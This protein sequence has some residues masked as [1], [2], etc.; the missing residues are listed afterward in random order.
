MADEP[1]LRPELFTAQG[2]ASVP[3]HPALLGGRC[4]SCGYTY[5]PMQLYGC[6]TCGSQDL[7]Q[8]PLSGRGR[9]VAFARVHMHVSPDRQAPFT[10]GSV[11]TD[12]G[13]VVRA[14]IDPASEDALR[15]GALM[16]ALLVAETRD[17]RG[18]DD[19]RFGL[20]SETEA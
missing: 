17:G 19:L 9:L 14:L 3:D 11:V 15:P 18:T 7:V 2:T 13:A 6:E 20:A 16:T 5:F 12:D 10:V 8:V 1:G 4:A